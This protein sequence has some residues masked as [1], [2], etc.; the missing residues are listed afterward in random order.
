MTSVVSNL[1]F[2]GV[3]LGSSLQVCLNQLDLA[4]SVKDGLLLI[5]SEESQDNSLLA[6]AADAYQVV[7]HC[8]LALMAAGLG[9]LAAP[10]VCKLARK[11]AK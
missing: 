7:G 4:Y 5:T 11:P 8:V 10:Y 3:P 9:G 2:A 6:N 1:D